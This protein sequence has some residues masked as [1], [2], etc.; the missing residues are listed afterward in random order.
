MFPGY[1]HAA[2][3]VWNREVGIPW[4]QSKVM[5]V[6]SMGTEECMCDREEQSQVS[7]V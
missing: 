3:S 7:V 6:S 1:Q 2:F 5:C 4:A